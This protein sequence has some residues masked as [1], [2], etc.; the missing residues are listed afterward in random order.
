MTIDT[1]QE[2]KNELKHARLGL[3]HYSKRIRQL[4]RRLEQLKVSTSGKGVADPNLPRTSTVF[5]LSLIGKRPK[6]SPQIIE[7]AI[8][9]L[10]LED[11]PKERIRKLR[12]RWSVM[13]IRLVKEGRIR[14]EGKGRDRTFQ[15]YSK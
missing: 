2:I 1:K 9:K 8:K 14:A 11:L 6:T 7:S 5:W 15:L 12:M 13:L 10:G 4:E 3:R